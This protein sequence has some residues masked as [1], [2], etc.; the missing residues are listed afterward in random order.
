MNRTRQ[1][2]TRIVSA[3]AVLVTALDT[4]MLGTYFLF[5]Y[6]QQSGRDDLAFTMA[7]KKDFPS[8]GYMLGHG[9]TTMWE[10]WDGYW[11]QIHSCYTCPGGWM[12]QGLAGIR[13]DEAGPGFKRIIIKPAV[14]GDLTW[15][16]CHYDSIHGRIVSNWKHEGG[17]L[18]MEVAIPANTMATVYVPA[19]DAAGVTES[20]KPAKA[21]EGVTFLRMEDSTAV[22]AVG[23]GTYRFQ[24]TLA[25][26]V[27]GKS[28]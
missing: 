11:S 27:R 18:T 14:V 13:P 8:L 20:G 2:T 15:V 7:T 3:W 23:S 16:R 19:K 22:Y 28:P 17:K 6:L 26:A 12:Y 9:A 24:S 1:A 10:Q 21:A 25:A 4:G 5:H